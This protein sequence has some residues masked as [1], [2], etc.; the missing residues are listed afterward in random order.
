MKNI[1]SGRKLVLDKQDVDTDQM[2]PARFLTT[3]S[4]K[5]LGEF[6]F[7]DLPEFSYEPCDS[8]LLAG[9]NFGCGSSREHAVWALQ[10]FGVKAVVA[11]SFGN[12]FKKNSG[13]SG[14]LLIEMQVESVK[15]LI[16]CEASEVR[17]DL[18]E[19]SVVCGR[20]EVEGNIDGFGKLCFLE[21]KDPLDLLL[22]FEADVNRS[23]K[24][25]HVDEWWQKSF[26]E[27]SGRL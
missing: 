20:S 1:L 4:K 7:V 8:I 10:D 18:S 26:G 12:I 16:S 15:E 5:G 21:Q 11:P 3:I 14:L 23:N 13:L 24:R 6:L 25:R 17:V 19:S 22:D 27:L 9:P 2:I